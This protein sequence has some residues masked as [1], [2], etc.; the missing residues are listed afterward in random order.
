MATAEQAAPPHGKAAGK[1]KMAH[2]A[3]DGYHRCENGARNESVNSTG[4]KNLVWYASRTRGDILLVQEHKIKLFNK[5]WKAVLSAASVGGQGGA[6]GGVAVL[7]ELHV[8]MWHA[9]DFEIQRGRAVY[10]MARIGS[11]GLIN[12]YSFYLTTGIGYTNQNKSLIDLAMEHFASHGRP[13]I[14]GADWN[15]DPQV[16]QT[17]PW[18]AV[19]ARV[20]WKALNPTCRTAVMRDIVVVEDSGLPTHSPVGLVFRT[21]PGM[22]TTQAFSKPKMVPTQRPPDPRPR[23]PIEE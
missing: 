19:K 6:S 11:L 14:A 17:A 16:L 15:F 5:G 21:Q 22:E 10:A 4:A 9:D 12:L 20:V 7:A 13:S 8:D 1:G 3:L 23:P 18:S 2:Q